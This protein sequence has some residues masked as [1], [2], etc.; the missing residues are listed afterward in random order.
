MLREVRE[1]IARLINIWSTCS[2]KNDNLFENVEQ[3]IVRK[4]LGN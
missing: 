2:I 3:V 1:N 4:Q